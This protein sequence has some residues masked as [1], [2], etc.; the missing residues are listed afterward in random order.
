MLETLYLEQAIRSVAKN[1]RTVASATLDF[2]DVYHVDIQTV[3]ETNHQFVLWEDI[4]LA[5]EDALHVRH[6]TRIVPFVEGGDFV[7]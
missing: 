6:Q 7:T 5:F 4:Q 1:S 2:A 3:P